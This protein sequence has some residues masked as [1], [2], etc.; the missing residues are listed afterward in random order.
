MTWGE[1]EVAEDL[2]KVASYA[3]GAAE[4]DQGAFNR[5]P[6]LPHRFSPD[7]TNPF[8]DEHYDPNRPRL[9]QIPQQRDKS[10]PFI[11]H[12]DS[13]PDYL[14]YAPLDDETQKR[15]PQEMQP[16]TLYRGIHINL[17]HPDYA[18]HPDLKKVKE[19]LHG[20][21]GGDDGGFWDTPPVQ[22]DLYPHPQSPK[23][24]AVSHHLLNF[25]E[26]VG[27]N[28]PKGKN[29][30]FTD[31][32]DKAPPTWLGRHWTI[33]RGNAEDFAIGDNYQDTGTA[34]NG[35]SVLLESDWDG[36]GEDLHRTNSGG[37]WS[38]E[39]EVTLSPGTALNVKG[40][41]IHHPH[42]SP[43][44]NDPNNY[45]PNRKWHNVLG[46]PQMRTASLR[47]L[48]GANGPLPAGITFKYHDKDAPKFPD[49]FEPELGHVDPSAFG[50]V[51]A[52]LPDG[53]MIGHLQWHDEHPRKK[54]EI[55]D[56]R[57]HPDHRRRG[58]ADAMFDWTTDNVEP[59]LY[60]SGNLSEDG[61]A[62]RANEEQRP[63]T[64]Q[65][66]DDWRNKRPLTR[67]EVYASFDPYGETIPGDPNYLYHATHD[68]NAQ[69]IKDYGHLDVHD[70]WHGTDQDAWPD[71]SVDPRS[72]W[73]HDPQV[74]RSFY[75]EGGNPTLLRT[76]R[77]NAPFQR[78]R[79]TGDFYSPDPVSA[80]HLE[81]YH[82]GGKWGPLHEW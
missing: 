59:D 75:P 35:L 32:W 2:P 1:V 10:Q 16:H 42:T 41:H 36:R 54:G 58:V 3:Y 26:D 17:D 29:H 46:Q 67:R 7:P 80:D 30:Q 11:P 65:R 48:G 13:D 27:Q 77:T 12:P 56:I 79:G 38:G 70:P 49:V 47:R 52:H 81:V 55:W 40:L 82:G 4:W 74:A 39:E 61:A 68:Y 5:Q 50:T 78:E 33:N 9:D 72:Y 34:R 71:G 45:D 6:Y 23:G 28:K 22:G 62:W 37:A 60:H 19:I 57:V 14:E 43:V 76:K 53:Q 25:I 69:D 24:Q 15:W 73:T 21:A 31:D 44:A 51:S 20:S 64:K 66:Y 8:D 63:I 18:D